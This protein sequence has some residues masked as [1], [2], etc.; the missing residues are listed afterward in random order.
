MAK[1]SLILP[2]PGADLKVLSELA[3]SA[4]AG[5]QD[6]PAL[7]FFQGGMA[8]AEY[9][10]GHW[11][12]AADLAQKSAEGLSPYSRAQAYAIL[13]MAQ[14]NLRQA[15]AARGSLAQCVDVIG[16][17][18]PKLEGGNLG[19]DWR[20]WIIAHALQSEAKRMIEG[21]PAV[22]RPADLRVR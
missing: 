4:L 13:A 2:R 10:Q 6:D 1:F 16:T 22:T 14:F 7:H 8:L 19:R 5:S 17:R 3:A 11:D 18:F 21:E 15:E 20:D 9:R 12:K